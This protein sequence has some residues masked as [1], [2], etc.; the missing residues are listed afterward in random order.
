MCPA[1]PWATLPLC[2]RDAVASPLLFCGDT[3]FSAGCGRMFE[4]TPAQ[5]SQALA[6][7]AAL[8]DDT[9]VCCTHEY[10]LANLRF[11]LAVE[12]GNADLVLYTPGAVPG[13]AAKPGS[14]RCLHPLRK[15]ASSTPS[16]VAANPPWWRRRWHQWRH[17]L[18]PRVRVRRAAQMEKPLLMQRPRKLCHPRQ[19]R[20]LCAVGRR[21]D[22]RLG[23]H[24]L[25]HAGAR[26]TLAG[27]SRLP[28]PAPTPSAPEPASA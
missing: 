23:N 9:Q 15:S 2:R 12:P 16:C 3:L 19:R 18:R 22:L 6:R 5:M 28:L 20:R 24:G 21:S 10:T 4:G 13:T 14:P 1:T 7:L 25:Q 26:R 27:R 8:P 11:A 17:R